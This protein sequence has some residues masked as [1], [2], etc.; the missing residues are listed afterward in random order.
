MAQPQA[1]LD[2]NQLISALI[3]SKGGSDFSSNTMD[4]VMQYLNGTYQGAPQFNISQLYERTA[5]TFMSAAALGPDSP[6]AVAAA[7]IKA[8]SAPW[9]LWQ[10]KQLQGMSG[11]T[12]EEWKSFI[13]DLATEQ[14]TVKKAML[15]QSLEQ[16]V[17]QKAGMRGANDS[18]TDVNEDGT[19]K[20]GADAYQYAPQQFDELLGNLPKQ[21]QGDI[22]RRAQVESKYGAPV[23]ETD[24]DK[25]LQMLY[26]E[27]LAKLNT[28][29]SQ[30]RLGKETWTRDPVTGEMVQNYTNPTDRIRFMAKDRTIVNGKSIPWI[31]T[32]DFSW[33]DVFNPRGKQ[34]ENPDMI[35]TMAEQM[36]RNP[37]SQWLGFKPLVDKLL[38]SGGL[39]SPQDQS[40]NAEIDAKELLK[41]L[42]DAAYENKK[43]SAIGRSDANAINAYMDRKQGSGVNSQRQAADLTAQILSSLAEQGS[44]PLKTDIMKNAML[45]R[46]TRNG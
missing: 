25:I 11:M 34:A 35:V 9:Q 8:G 20:F 45:K 14:Q 10:D 27:S 32:A 18:Y 43:A 30:K 17:F 23:M 42:G 37:F 31:N 12:P 40:K 41:K 1:P 44:T 24:K 29:E 19:L 28:K 15:D 38:F 36:V 4:P 21:Q 6:H 46:T 16:D 26:N 3:A 33:K 7:R 5:P 13:N 22:I 2:F 39:T